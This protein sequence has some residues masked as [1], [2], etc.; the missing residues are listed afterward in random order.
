MKV[1]TCG[2][3]WEV[4]NASFCSL[5]GLQ[6]IFREA[7][8][9]IETSV[10]R[11]VSLLVPGA[12]GVNTGEDRGPLHAKSVPCVASKPLVA[13]REP[14][15]SSILDTLVPPLHVGDHP[16]LLFPSPH[17]YFEMGP[18]V[19]ASPQA[20]FFSTESRQQDSRSL[21]SVWILGFFT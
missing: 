3:Q 1:E 11:G 4:G 17:Y 18:P 5:S 16:Y 15:E 20:A 19:T 21:N 7:L 10:S 12:A 6:E 9:E 2:T 8:R 13:L 14:P